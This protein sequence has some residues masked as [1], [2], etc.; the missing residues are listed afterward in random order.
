MFGKTRE[1]IDTFVSDRVTSP[2]RTAVVISVAAFTMAA[3]ALLLTAR[4][5]NAGR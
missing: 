5:V 4:S 3:L 2:V 1:R